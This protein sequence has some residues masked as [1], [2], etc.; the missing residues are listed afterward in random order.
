MRGVRINILI[1]VG[2]SIIGPPAKR[3]MAFRWRAVDGTTL[4]AGLVVFDF[5]TDPDQYF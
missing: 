5:P 4:N 3:Q 2:H 1:K